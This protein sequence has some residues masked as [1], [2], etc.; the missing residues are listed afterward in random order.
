MRYS[1]FSLD[2]MIKFIIGAC[3]IFKINNKLIPFY[4]KYM[5]IYILYCIQMSDSTGDGDS[6]SKALDEQL[7]LLTSNVTS[8]QKESERQSDRV[9]ELSSLLQNFQLWAGGTIQRETGEVN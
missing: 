6:E 1:I 3:P 2:N 5:Y 9:N 4:I 8:L 7:Q